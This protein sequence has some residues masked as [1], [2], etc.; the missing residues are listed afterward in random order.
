MTRWINDP[1][2]LTE[3]LV[4]TSDYIEN[5]SQQIAP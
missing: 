5:G 2:Y 3:P 4:R 1:R